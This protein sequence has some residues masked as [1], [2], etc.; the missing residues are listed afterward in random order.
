MKAQYGPTYDVLI[1]GAGVSGAALLY[2][3]SKY[4]NAKVG[5]IEKYHEP[6]LVNTDP[7]QNSQTLHCG[8]IE[9]NYTLEKAVSVR[10]ASNILKR[11]ATA[12]HNADKIIHKMPKMV[13]GVGTEEAYKL[14]KRFEQFS[15]YYPNLRLLDRHQINEIEPNVIKGRNDAILAMGSTDDY[16]AVNFEALTHSFIN[17]ANHVPFVRQSE[18]DL[19]YNEQVEKITRNDNDEFMV[20]TDKNRYWAR[21][22]VVCAGGHSLKIAHQMGYGLNLSVLPVAGSYYFTPQVLNGKVYTVQNDKLPFA[23][24]HGDPDVVVPGPTR[25]GPKAAK[26]PLRERDNQK[27]TPEFFVLLRFDKR[28]GNALWGLFGDNVNGK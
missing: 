6:A 16:A 26:H 11:Y 15:P 9:T 28:V 18:H 23:A 20:K 21:S 1:I 24:I 17:N 19:M 8:D 27:K 5:V 25:F 13:I 3:L 10:N 2:M 14:Q 7:T 4:T 22:V 12:Q